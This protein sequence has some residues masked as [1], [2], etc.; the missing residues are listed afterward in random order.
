MKTQSKTNLGGFNL[1]ALKPTI[2]ATA[3]TLLAAIPPALL[4][5][6]PL[7][8]WTARSS[9]TGQTLCSVAYG[10]SNYVA[11]GYGGTVLSSSNGVTWVSRTSGTSLG[12]YSVTY[13][14]NK[15]AAVGQII[16]SS[17]NGINWTTRDTGSYAFEAVAYVNGG[18]MTVGDNG[19]MKVSADGITWS[20]RNSGTTTTLY[21]LAYGNGTY[22][23][24]GAG[25]T[26]RT[27]P[28]GLT[29][30]NRTSG[31]ASDLN[32]VT[33]GGGLFVAQG[34]AGVIL[35]STNG[36]D[37]SSRT[38]GT[39]QGLATS[40]CGFGWFV[41][42]GMNGTIL[43]STNGTDWVAKSSG[44]T[45]L[46][47][48]D[49]AGPDSFGAVGNSGSVIQSGTFP[50]LGIWP[51][52]KSQT[53]AVGQTA[54]FSVGAWGAAPLRFQWRKYTT[55]LG[56]ET[57]STLN[58]TNVQ[59][60][61]AGD[62][63]VV[64]TNGSGAVTSGVATL[65]VAPLLISPQP[66]DQTL[67]VGATASFSAGV[68]GSGTLS[69]QWRKEGYAIAGATNLTCAITNVQLSDAGAFTFVA[70]NSFGSATSRV[71]RLTVTPYHPMPGI[72]YFKDSTVFSPFDMAL[73]NLGLHYDSFTDVASLNNALN[74]VTPSSALVIIDAV[75]NIH[76]FSA[77]VGFLAQGGRV[78]L[79][80]W[81]LGPG[82][83]ESAFQVTDYT[84]LISPLPVY[85]WGGSPFF[86]GVTSPLLLYD[87]V[88]VDGHT[89][90]A[91]G[92]AYAVAGFVSSPTVNQAA[93]V[94]GN[95][96]RSIVN[97]FLGEETSLSV[98]GVRFAQ[99]E[100]QFL[101]VPPAPQP[102][103]TFQPQDQALNMFGN[104]NFAVVV[105]GSGA[106]RY[107]WF[108]NQTN[109]LP[110]A[111]NATLTVTNVQP[112]DAGNYSVVVS[113]TFGSATSRLAALT[114]GNAPIPLNIQQLNGTVVL[115]WSSAAFSL[116]A[117]PAADGVY[118]NVPGA[119][120]PYTNAATGSQEFFRLKWN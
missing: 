94:V 104:A 73:F 88:F 97:G 83:V 106:L 86:D 31:T 11:V 56:G 89:L 70:S 115:S 101:L 95:T 116:Q 108:F 15:F 64:L 71:A 85:N 57:N 111:T 74:I 62:Y 50:P 29:W 103:I 43:A 65:T 59:L 80:Y 98:D 66:Q 19:V 77:L 53:V 102:V 99:N 9:P 3:L 1:R 87:L 51:Q 8:S 24:V 61:T 35:T 79:Q 27:S 22:V 26:I 4:R 12:L 68:I 37:W 21:G 67:Q 109:A 78:L 91:V 117:A 10:V 105:S 69:Y 84:T 58:L 54:Q 48:G 118:T 113:N 2:L 13:G 72:L 18:F 63:S 75:N 76:D 30:T 92:N 16:L 33:Y 38:S 90:Q 100:I 23:V 40:A 52:P 41:I 5:A 46:L 81:N 114:I 55:P 17:T 107:Q 96:N 28:D 110:S 20:N 47:I 14:S 36:L 7:D 93:V 119:T 60:A 42:V 6:D 112:A 82:S 45:S 120:S 44:T 39:G 25:G 34:N 32:G 49:C